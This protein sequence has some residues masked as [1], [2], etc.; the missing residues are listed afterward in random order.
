MH[1]KYTSQIDEKYAIFFV[2]TVFK[3]LISHRRIWTTQILYHCG[4]MIF[5]PND[6]HQR[7]YKTLKH[8]T[9]CLKKVYIDIVSYLKKQFSFIPV[10]WLLYINSPLVVW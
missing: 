9:L 1:K 4:M 10:H 7:I 8:W 6:W 2:T 3:N 5:N